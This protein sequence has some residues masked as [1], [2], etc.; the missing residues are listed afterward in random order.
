MCPNIIIY[1]VKIFK[2]L[3]YIILI[4]CNNLIT[5]LLTIGEYIWD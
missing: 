1:T 2:I 5:L 3:V 4:E